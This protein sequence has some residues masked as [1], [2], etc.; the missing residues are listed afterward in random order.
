MM[1]VG[2]AGCWI[3]GA[4]CDAMCAITALEMVQVKGNRLVL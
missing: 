1:G 3:Y 2:V 4:G